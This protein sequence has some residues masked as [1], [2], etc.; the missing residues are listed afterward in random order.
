MAGWHK[1]GSGGEAKSA[2]LAFDAKIHVHV[3][4]VFCGFYQTFFS[5]S[6]PLYFETII[7]FLY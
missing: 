3:R 6:S 4:D 1:N 5:S 2:I 7:S